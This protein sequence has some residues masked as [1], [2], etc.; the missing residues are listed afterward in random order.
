MYVDIC[1]RIEGHAQLEYIMEKSKLTAVNFRMQYHRGFETILA[2]K[3]PYDIPRLAS[4]ICGLCPASQ[5]ISSCLAVEKLLGIREI[6]QSNIIRRALLAAD[7][8]KSH[9]MHFIFQT[10]PDLHE[11][12]EGEPLPLE[13]LIPE[14]NDLVAALFTIIQAGKR[15]Q[16]CFGGR[17]V[18]PINV[19]P[20][21]ILFIPDAGEL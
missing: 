13:K 9:G 14:K 1:T 2:Q 6:F 11:L 18:H 21:G 19:V 12:V 15:I 8:L 10:L 4:R 7:I 17:A 20:G 5:A 3:L 16:E